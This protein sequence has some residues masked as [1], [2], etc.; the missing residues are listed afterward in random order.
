MKPRRSRSR[1]RRWPWRRSG[2][3]SKASRAPS[4]RVEPPFPRRGPRPRIRRSRNMERPRTA[5]YRRRPSR[6]RRQ[7]R[8]RRGDKVSTP[9]PEQPPEDDGELVEAV[10]AILAVQATAEAPAEDLS[11]ALD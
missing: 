7:S 4:R 11:A 5:E 2:R 3:A 9:P 6:R 10:L 8:T 1:R